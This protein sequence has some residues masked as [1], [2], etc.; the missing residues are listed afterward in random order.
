MTVQERQYAS[1]SD[2]SISSVAAE[3]FGVLMHSPG[4]FIAIQFVAIVPAIVGYVLGGPT[5]L[6]PGQGSGAWIIVILAMVFGSIA[7]AAIT[8]GAFESLRGHVFTVGHAVS[9]ALSRMG[10]IF[11]V[12][13]T[14]TVIYVLGIVLLVVPGV[15]AMCMLYV[16]LPVCVVERAGVGDSIGRSRTL[17]KGFRWKIFGQVL[18]VYIPI[19]IAIFGIVYVIRQMGLPILALWVQ[20][21]LSVLL[22]SFAGILGAVTY[23]RLRNLQEG[24]DLERIAA[25][26]D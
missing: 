18:A 25:V 13:I 8:V 2:Y 15:I 1:S 12:S 16:A 5:A 23:F 7:H 3:T 10:T 22:G 20:Q 6:V 14:L 9:V 11:V 4:K 17:T 26:F 19:Y 24:V 21:L